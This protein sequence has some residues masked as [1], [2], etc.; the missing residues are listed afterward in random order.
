MLELLYPVVLAALLL[1]LSKI[2]KRIVAELQHKDYL[3]WFDCASLA[4][5]ACLADYAQLLS[6]AVG[7]SLQWRE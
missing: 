7:W 6:H 5:P 1:L 3:V 4:A 2:V